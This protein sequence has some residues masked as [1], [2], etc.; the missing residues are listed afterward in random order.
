ME[1]R[2]LEY[3][4]AV[5]EEANF[6]RA[7]ERVHISQ[8]GVSAQIRQLENDLGARLFDRSGRTARLTPAGVATL[9]HARSAIASVEAA[10]QAVDE[11]NGL[12]RG[13]LVVGMV[14]ACTVTT[15]FDALSTFHR[16]HP[17]VD[18]TLVEDTSDRLMERLRANTL[19]LALVGTSVTPP[20]DLESYEIAREPLVAA[21]PSGHPLIEQ[22]RA[23]LDALERYSL[24]SLPT[25]AGVR[26]A[27]DD[28][29]AARGVRLRISLQASA[30][31]AVADLAIRGLGVAILSSSMAAQ[32]AP[33]LTALPI[34]HVDTETVLSL[35]WTSVTNPATRHL[36]RHCRRSFTGSRPVAPS[37]PAPEPAPEPS[38]HG[39]HDVQA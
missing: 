24:I 1:L 23:T 4:I 31:A 38:A 9:E 11:V 12:I 2:Q 37:A 13:K 30:P 16:S 35:V 28:A 14:T 20:S 7:A 19:D 25:G 29:C 36:I 26:A 6:T 39:L 15:L 22:G 5:A 17:G 33:W 21:V 3:F 32:Q 27:F 8:S 10:R 34:E 18:I